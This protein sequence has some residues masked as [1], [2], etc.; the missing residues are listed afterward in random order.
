MGTIPWMSN[1]EGWKFCCFSAF[2]GLD[3]QVTRADTA[4]PQAAAASKAQPT[5]AASQRLLGTLCIQANWVVPVS[6][7]LATRGPP[8]N[9]PIRHGTA[10]VSVTRKDTTGLPRFSVLARLPQVW[11]AAQ[12]VR[13]AWYCDAICRPVMSSKTANAAMAAAA[14]YA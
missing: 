13:A 14:K 3:H 12:D 4:P 2:T 5:L 8:Q 7:S 9:T 11:L 6:T 1:C 10:T